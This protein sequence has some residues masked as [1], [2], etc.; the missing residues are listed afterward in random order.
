M[1]RMSHLY[2][3]QNHLGLIKIGKTRQLKIRLGRIE[4]DDLC[5]VQLVSLHQDKGDEEQKY[6]SH[7]EPYRLVG[8]WLDGHDRARKD[9][10][11]HLCSGPATQWPFQ[12]ASDS[13]IA[14][15]L[16]EV[17]AKRSA[18]SKAKLSQRFIRKMEN[19][20]ERDGSWNLHCDWKI[21][22][23]IWEYD[24][25]HSYQTIPQKIDSI[26]TTL[27][28]FGDVDLRFPLPKFTANISD[29]LLTWPES[30]RP[31]RWSGTAWD[32]CIE[33]LKARRN[34]MLSRH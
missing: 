34:N 9:I 23:I 5:T 2:I 16:D 30:E 28:S 33:G 3:I 12:P 21:G 8:E 26:D 6:L 19:F 15:W 4:R 13:K 11:D 22:Q 20:Y 10:A 27:V 1:S 7:F 14:K 24:E 32:C 31:Q 18:I 25:E 17:E 29:A